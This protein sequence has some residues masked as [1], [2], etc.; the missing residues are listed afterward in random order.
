M[1]LAQKKKLTEF[2]LSGGDRC[3]N[4]KWY[5]T[6]SFGRECHHHYY[7]QIKPCGFFEDKCSY[8]KPDISQKYDEYQAEWN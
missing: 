1:K 3:E 4:C 8:V 7:H 2:A 6:D 5:W